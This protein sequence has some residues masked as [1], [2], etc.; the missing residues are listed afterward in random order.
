MGNELKGAVRTGKER[1]QGK[2]LL[3][4]SELTFRG[5]DYRLKI[6]FGEWRIARCNER[7][8]ADV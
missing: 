1:H 7:R 2:I 5:T 6:A 4:T 8:S 3:E